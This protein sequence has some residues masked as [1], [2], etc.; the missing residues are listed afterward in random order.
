MDLMSMTKDDL[1]I[2]AFDKFGVELDLSKRIKKLRA[3]V[4]LLEEGGSLE[5]EEEEDEIPEGK[6][7]MLKNPRTGLSFPPTKQLMARTDLLHVYVDIPKPAVEDVTTD[8]DG[9][10]VLEA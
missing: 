5:E 9:N 1:A 6:R 3:E 7:L 4:L 10:A 8:S 2:H